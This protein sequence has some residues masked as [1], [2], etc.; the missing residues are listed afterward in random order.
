[1][2]LANVTAQPRE[3]QLSL[4]PVKCR[5]TLSECSLLERN[6]FSAHEK[7][8]RFIYF[9]KFTPPL[10]VTISVN[11]HY[12]RV[13]LN[14]FFPPQVKKRQIFLHLHTWATCTKTIAITTL[15]KFDFSVQHPLRN[16]IQ[17]IGLLHGAVFVI[18]FL[19]RCIWIVSVIQISK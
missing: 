3:P 7:V 15:S 13:F 1:M 4:Y 12:F 6:E 10:Q 9:L 16:Y 14:Y 18:S 17:D 8:F 2:R 11:R 19:G 5:W